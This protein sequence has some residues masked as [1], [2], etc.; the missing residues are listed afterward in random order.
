MA[1]NESVLDS[2]RPHSGGSFS[3]HPLHE[4]ALR[5]AEFGLAKPRAR[6]RDL[7]ALLVSHG[8]RAWRS[9]QPQVQVH[10]HVAIQAGRRPVHLRLR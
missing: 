2:S 1:N 9:G 5:I 10:L 7:V 3:L 6:T 8:A 4:A